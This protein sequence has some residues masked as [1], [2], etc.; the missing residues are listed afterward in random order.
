MNLETPW[1]SISASQE[2]VYT[3]LS[4]LNNLEK[5]M[6]EQVINWKSSQDDCSFTI[7]GMADMTLSIVEKTPSSIVKMGSSSAKPFPFSLTA[8][9]ESEN[10]TSK[11]RLVFDGKVNAFMSM[12]IEKPLGNFFNML[13]SGLEK[14]YNN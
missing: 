7:K 8:Q 4:D 2:D 10:D 6:P 12:M 3:F 11:V 13:L 5:L 14:Q 9:I 1:K